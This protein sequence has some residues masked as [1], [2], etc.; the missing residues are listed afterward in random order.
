MKPKGSPKKNLFK[1]RM[2]E[3][4]EEALYP[5]GFDDAIIG[6]TYRHPDGHIFLMS[7]KKIIDILVAQGMSH[8]EATEYF[9][10]NM[11]NAYLGAGS[12]VYLEDEDE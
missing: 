5:S 1:E 9:E 4:S 2:R 12:P 11:K 7:S 8:S 6:I 10:F 3:L